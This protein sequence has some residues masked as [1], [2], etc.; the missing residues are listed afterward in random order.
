[1]PDTDPL[2]PLRT[3]WSVI[4]AAQGDEGDAA[5]R[6]NCLEYLAR[7]YREP[8]RLIVR[9]LGIANP[10][11]VDDLVQD[12][13]THF[14]EKSLL[15]RLDP[16]RGRF[17]SFLH[18]SVRN[19]VFNER[20]KRKRRPRHLPL[21]PPNPEESDLGLPEPAAPDDTALDRYNRSWAEAVMA[22][23]LDALKSDPVAGEGTL[24]YAVFERHVLAPERYGNP[25]YDDSAT[26]LSCLRSDVANHLHRVKKR[27][28]TILRRVIRQTVSTESEVDAEMEDLRQY[29]GS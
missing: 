5:S 23:A 20:D 3:A 28:H 7:T 9:T 24:Y 10:D 16:E 25:S 15:D 14:L 21:A 27:L 19:F 18:V 26:E 29:L 12:Y 6:E 8:V 17:R 13:F 2:D 22:A 1:M 4:L 11:E